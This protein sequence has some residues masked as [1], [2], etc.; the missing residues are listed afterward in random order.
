MFAVCAVWSLGQAASVAQAGSGD[1][2]ASPDYRFEVASIRP[3]EAPDGQEYKTHPLGPHYGP[4]RFSEEK[5][6]LGS[7]M[8]M[9]FKT[10]HV[11]EI[12]APGWTSQAY[13]NIG[14]TFP[15][16]AA[17][18]DVPIM[19]QHLLEDRFALKFHRETR[20]IAG[21]Q[22]V[23]AK[24]GVK[25]APGVPPDPNQPKGSPYEFG[26]DG[27]TFAKNAR[28][29]YFVGGSPCCTAH[30][31]ETNITMKQLATSL[32]DSNKLNAPVVDATGLEGTYGFTLV[33]T[34]EPFAGR[35]A[36]MIGPIPATA[37]PP[38]GEGGATPPPEHPFMRDA[39]QEQI[40]LKVQPVKDVLIDVVVVDSINKEPTEN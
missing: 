23:V 20:H 18:G 10:K 35:G 13:F 40:G 22:L 11:F 33:Y 31:L 7:L 3:S 30:W 17:K 15:E 4:D 29:G 5:I 38:T 25:L 19:M 14:G 28:S 27:M 6:S 24:S 26:K 36:V 8:W 12:E 9:A 37:A 39:L 1:P 16:G 32:A 21:Y 2:A 34:P